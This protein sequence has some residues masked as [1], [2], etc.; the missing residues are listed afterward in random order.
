MKDIEKIIDMTVN[1]TILKLK[2]AGLM[3]DNQKSAFQKTEEL[4]KNYQ[5]FRLSNQPYTIKLVEKIDKAL[6]SVK[7]DPY[8]DLIRMA[9]FDGM[10]REE[11]AENFN[12]T[13]TTISRNKTRLVNILK[14]YLFSD[15][16]IY[17]LF[18]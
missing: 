3:K 13:V 2:M 14:S 15:D 16:V 7:D 10:T 11:M 6:N 4:L 1:K 8:Y 9:Y 18:L 17:E 12:T 5:A